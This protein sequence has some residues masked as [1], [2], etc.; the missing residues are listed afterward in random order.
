MISKSC[1]KPI[2]KSCVY[3]KLPLTPKQAN[4]TKAL[5][6]HRTATEMLTKLALSFL[7]HL[8]PQTVMNSPLNSCLQCV[9]FQLFEKDAPNT[10]LLEP[11]FRVSNFLLLCCATFMACWWISSSFVELILT[12]TIFDV[13]VWPVTHILC[14][15]VW[16]IE[17]CKLLKPWN[18]FA[19]YGGGSCYNE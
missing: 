7:V 13:L 14:Q 1:G 5:T 17:N 4:S 12:H 6:K 8:Y 10:N 15:T 19:V 9:V 18:L 16:F 2:F 11:F 3:S